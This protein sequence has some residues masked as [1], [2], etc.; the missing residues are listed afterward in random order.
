[1]PPSTALETQTK[2]S[3]SVTLRMLRPTSSVVPTTSPEAGSM[4][5]TLPLKLFVT[6]TKRLPATIPIGL[7][8]TRSAAA[9]LPTRGR[10]G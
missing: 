9:P 6:Q 1:M 10:C 2:P 8:P 3:A 7:L 5:L 4:R